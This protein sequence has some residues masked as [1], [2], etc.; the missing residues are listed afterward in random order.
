MTAFSSLRQRFTKLLEAQ[1]FDLNVH[2]A[3]GN[4]VLC[5]GH[6]EIHIPQVVFIA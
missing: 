2:L 4:A 6:L 1:A 3:R 5:S